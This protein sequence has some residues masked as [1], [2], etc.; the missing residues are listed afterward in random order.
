MDEFTNQRPI[1]YLITFFNQYKNIIFYICLVILIS[2]IVIPQLSNIKQSFEVTNKIKPLWLV[3]G[4]IISL[5]TFLFSALSFYVLAKKPIKYINTVLIQCASMFA[6]HLLPAGIGS[7]G[8]MFRYLKLNRHSNSEAASVV[9]VNNI[10]GFIG[11]V[12]ILSYILV[13]DHAPLKI[14]I[15]TKYN[16]LL[17]VIAVVAFLFATLFFIKFRHIGKKLI[18]FLNS[19]RKSTN[20]YRHKKASLLISLMSIM[21]LTI[22]YGLSLCTC[23]LAIGVH[24]SLA[25]TLVVLAIGV[26]AKSV[27][28]TPGGIIGAEA[29]IFAGLLSYG[30]TG[31]QAILV[32][33]SYRLITYWL[34][35]ALGGVAITYV[36]KLNYI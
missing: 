16:N 20:E 34:P 30:M 24:I 10:L 28:P 8:V 7:I 19:V 15:F 14:N 22:L 6:N 21:C 17:L 18:S 5:T 12:L 36:K 9:Y 32:I 26:I 23:A 33:I 3:A 31:A 25:E 29:G 2:I 35:F 1:R 11:Y 4:F 27:V 13:F